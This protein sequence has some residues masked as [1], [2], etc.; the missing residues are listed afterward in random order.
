MPADTP[1]GFTYPLYTDAQNTA[2]AIEE[3]AR[4][5]DTQIADAYFQA[6]TA[7][8]GPSCKV[9]RG[10][11]PHA[12][13]NGVTTVVTFDTEIYDPTGLMWSPGLPTIVTIP[14]DGEYLV[15]AF[16]RFDQA[17]TGGVAMFINQS[18]GPVTMPVTVTKAPD[19]DRGTTVS[20]ATLCQAFFGENFS[21]SLR[22]N[23][24]AAMSTFQ[25]DFT[26]TRVSS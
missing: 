20:A 13:A 12:I 17:A 11:G 16:A 7:F 26:V 8:N 5:F 6:E 1:R 3:L 14:V 18:G 24:G 9:Q 19:N 4:D 23:S 22:Q 15:T 21:V 25:V 2:A 10:F